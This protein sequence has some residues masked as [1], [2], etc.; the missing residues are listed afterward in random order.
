MLNSAQQNGHLGNQDYHKNVRFRNG[1]YSS[2]W[3]PI[4]RKKA[5]LFS[6]Y[7]ASFSLILPTTAAVNFCGLWLM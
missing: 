5:K 2:N 7:Y 6:D 1:I 3:L 4:S